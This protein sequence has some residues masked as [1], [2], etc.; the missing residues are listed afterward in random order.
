VDKAG[1]PVSKAHLWL[2]T[3]E[4][5]YKTQT[6][7]E[8]RAVW[9]NA[10]D[11][12][13]TFAFQA[14]GFLRVDGVKVRPDGE[15]HIITLP[16]ALVVHGTSAL[17]VHGAVYDADTSQR[18]PRFRIVEGW[19][20]PNPANGTNA[21]WSTI[22]RHWLDF[23]NGAYS[24]SFEEP[25]VGGTE[26]R[27]YILKFMADGYAPFIS[28]VIGPNEGNVQLN[29]VL[30]RAVATVVTVNKPD[31]QPA[32]NADVGLVFP[33]ACLWLIQGG[34]NRQNVQ[35][36]G[37]LLRTKADGTF[38]LQ[39]DDSITRVIAA[40]SDGYVEVAPATLSVNPV[41]QLQP[42]GQLRVTY[43][44][45]GK[46]AAGREYQLELGGGSPETVSFD[47]GM[48]IVKTDEQGRF[49]VAQMPPGRHQLTRLYVQSRTEHGT[50]WEGGDETSFEIRPGET[51]TLNLGASNYTVIAKIHW[52]DGI[53]REP[54]WKIGAGLHT[55]MPVIP[56]EVMT[57]ETARV[58]FLQT[59]EFKAAQQNARSYQ[60]TINGDD[61]LSVDEVRAGDYELG[62]FV[63]EMPNGNTAPGSYVQP[64]RLFQGTLNVTIP[65]DPP[66][67][68]LDAGVIEL[69]TAPVS[70]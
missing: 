53:R 68:N 55:P 23:G 41:M 20:V 25:V 33:G 52:P 47:F 27:G 34:F 17:V 24:N 16:S 62:V 21:E 36:G 9:T 18:I 38:E 5:E 3:F 37:S 43:I 64:R 15:E 48:S 31:G 28:R 11:T 46:P 2:D 57:N 59:D 51:T 42:W 54:Q 12:E 65:A 56:P 66:S 7:C 29:V 26:N 44:S 49:S 58:A 70:P 1:N 4:V 32:N 67:G 14:S 40:S 60:A 19:P 50:S 39:P 69:Q 63:F 10:P 6:D 22:G 45:G 13:L 61:T 8:G 35:T 30:H